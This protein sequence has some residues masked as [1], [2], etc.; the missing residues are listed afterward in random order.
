[1]KK[2]KDTQTFLCLICGHVWYLLS[3]KLITDE[4][5]YE[6]INEVYLEH[7]VVCGGKK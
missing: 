6:W 4:L 5:F 7:E 2:Y 3:D 1:M